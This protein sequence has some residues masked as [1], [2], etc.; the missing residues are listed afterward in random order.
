MIAKKAREKAVA[1]AE[2]Q[3][4]Y[5]L[6]LMED[7]FSEDLDT[8][9]LLRR[10]VAQINARH[11]AFHDAQ[12]R[13]RLEI[14]ARILDEEQNWQQNLCNHVPLHNKMCTGKKQKR[15]QSKGRYNGR[16]PSTSALVGEQSAKPSVTKHL[17]PECKVRAHS[18]R[19]SDDGNSVEENII[20][21]NEE[22]RCSHHLTKP[23][24][25]NSTV[26]QEDV[27]TI[28]RSFVSRSSLHNYD[29]YQDRKSRNTLSG[30]EVLGVGKRAEED[31]TSEREQL[32]ETAVLRTRENIT[33]PQ[34]S[35]VRELRGPAFDCQPPEIWFKDFEPNTTIKTK[36]KL[37]N[38]S[39]KICTCRF[40]GLS[41]QL[42]DFVTVQF[43]PSGALS[44]GMS[45]IAVVTFVPKIHQDLK[46]QMN[47]LCPTG[48]FSVPFKAT[49]KKCELS[50]DTTT[51]EFGHVVIG[52]TARRSVTLHNIGARGVNFRFQKMIRSEQRSEESGSKIYFCPRPVENDLNKENGAIQATVLD[53]TVVE[54]TEQPTAE[55]GTIQES[56]FYCGSLTS[57]F[58]DAFSSVTLEIVWCPKTTCFFEQDILNVQAEVERFLITFDD[59]ACQPYEIFARGFPKELPTTLSNET[60]ILGICYLDRLY[61]D[62]FAVY[63]KTNSAL[64]VTFKWDS[65]VANHLT[66]CPKTGFAQAH[67]RL[68][69]QVKF[70]PKSTIHSDLC[71]IHKNYQSKDSDERT[72][73]DLLP[74]FEP[75]SGVLEVPVAV[76]VSGQ[77]NIL[78]LVV[79]AVVTKTDLIFI[80]ESLDF[81]AAEVNE[82]V[83]K[84]LR[85][86][87][88]CML[89][90]KFGIVDLPQCI[91][92]QPN[93]GFGILPPNGAVQLEFLFSPTEPKDYCFQV[94]CKTEI[95][96]KFYLTCSG[97][98]VL[99]PIKLSANDL[100]FPPTPLWET[101]T[102][103]FT[104]RN[105]HTSAD[106]YT[107]KQPRIGST[108]PVFPVGPIAFELR[109]IMSYFSDPESFWF[110][111]LCNDATK[112]IEEDFL[113]IHP[114]TGT[115][116]PGQSQ[117]IQVAFNP[118][119]STATIKELA[120]RMLNEERKISREAASFTL[121]QNPSRVAK[122]KH[123]KISKTKEVSPSKN[124]SKNYDKHIVT[125]ECKS[126]DSASSPTYPDDVSEDSLIFR[127]T[128]SM[129]NQLYPCSIT[130][131]LPSGTERTCANLAFD[132]DLWKCQWPGNMLIYQLACF[133]TDG[134][135][136][137]N[138][139]D[140]TPK[141]RTENTLFLQLACPIVRPPLLVASNDGSS[142]IDFGPLC[143]G[144]NR[145][146]GVS[147]QNISPYLLQLTPR[148]LLAS[149]P[150]ELVGGICP[151]KVGETQKIRV[152]FSPKFIHSW[153][154]ESLQLLAEP[155]LNDGLERRA[156][157]NLWSYPF[158][159]KLKGVCVIPRR[160]RIVTGF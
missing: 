16:K 151:M 92:V 57:G 155:V 124:A 123:R 137:D 74:S 50:I 88:N 75:A 89:P 101:S 158:S 117:L 72:Q 138:S 143:A 45:C 28:V 128:L 147:V 66:I 37:T 96:R 62:C 6:A 112:C 29:Q 110:F 25:I 41:Q 63:N 90:Q 148:P 104:I 34:Q 35:G 84:E 8:E 85:I 115:L 136:P 67:G 64:R 106:P 140:P 4:E 14:V 131:I 11:K 120:S 83:S 43:P 21:E 77:A 133:V 98:G 103:Q 59:E 47:F 86:V 7:E 79:A 121:D 44:P 144:Q 127:R 160:N 19:Q 39:L 78:K 12:S 24:P 9:L 113:T 70:C 130:N 141:Y 15:V 153:C 81:G 154:N 116:L 26:L 55:V 132:S 60:M 56:D 27:D 54:E 91:E 2:K 159:L 23:C 156:K 69:A 146:C 102:V 52:E 61:E 5:G 3:E 40:V 22:D 42:M 58:L 93:N 145:I 99:T 32:T 134:P 13:K 31:R 109:P 122:L 94:A 119:I 38:I 139:S 105:I 95:G 30:T 10:R 48:A 135:G 53:E 150:F 142:C 36:L 129:L 100:Q 108:G 149:G 71:S 65:S 97:I 80:P 51:V 46:G 118:C 157:R 33:Q 1:D 49:T 17:S 68:L 82:T 125:A 107:H 152:K 20:R 73:S 114:Q 111:S 87:N 126:I 76:Y 18:R